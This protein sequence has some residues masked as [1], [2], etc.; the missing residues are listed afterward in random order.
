MNCLQRQPPLHSF[1][2]KT[3]PQQ[4]LN[5]HS[6]RLKCAINLHTGALLTQHL[7]EQY[8]SSL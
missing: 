8:R 5:S 4:T 7:L 6:F 1:K 2:K 3:G